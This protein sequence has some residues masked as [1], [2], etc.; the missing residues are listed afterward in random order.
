MNRFF[1]NIGPDLAKQHNKRWRYYGETLHDNI[2]SFVT[3][4]EEVHL[5]CKDIN[6]MKSSGIDLLSARLC[7]D[8]FLVLE[9]QMV[10]I[11][12]SSLATGTFPDKWKIGKIIPLFKGGDRESV[13]NYR[14][15]SLLPLPGKMLEKIVHSRIIKFWEENKFLSSNQGGFRKNHSTVSTIADLTDDLFCQINEGNTTIAAFVNLRKA[16]DTVNT[17]IL[18]DKL[19]NAGI[20]GNVLKW[21]TN[22]LSNRSQCTFVNNVKSRLLPVTCGVPQGSALGPLFFLVYVNDIH[23]AV[24]SCGVKIYADDTVLYQSGVNC[25]E[26]ET[27]LEDSVNKFKEWCD[28]N[29]LTINASKTKVMVFGSRS[30]VKKCKDL[31]IRIEG[32]KLKMVPY[33]KISASPLTQH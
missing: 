10:H 8:A 11:F 19:N 4:V 29:V 2:E 24:Q 20:R 32:E 26:A 28:V 22:Y 23:D 9:Q 16:F 30:K 3:N 7:K 27:K 31:D 5:L 21:C 25:N 15:V 12:N 33:L 13:N 17:K 6:I 18:L 14:P 1:T